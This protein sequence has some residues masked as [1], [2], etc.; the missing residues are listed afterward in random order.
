MHT[1]KKAK[2]NQKT[3]LKVIIC[4]GLF[5]L[6]LTA[7]IFIYSSDYSRADRTAKAALQSTGAVQVTV[8]ENEVLFYPESGSDTGLIFYP[9]G[10]VEYTAYAPLLH[11]LAEEGIT[12]IIV[13]MPLQL[14]FLDI[15]AANRV[16]NEHPEINHWYLAGHSLGG[17]AASSYAQKNADKLDGLIL[18]ASYSTKPLS[19]FE[20]L[21]VY[22]S[23][24]GVLNRS[25]Y[26]ESRA[27][28]PENSKELV[29]SGGNHAQFGN[30]GIQDGDGVA[31]ISTE[32][33][34]EIT[35]NEILE[36]IRRRF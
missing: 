35:R 33:Q 15:N 30:Y 10:K 8:S 11:S 25:A 23:E 1:I 19:G 24:D 14:A 6:L 9:G 4:I 2:K 5:V 36:F 22:G 20:V 13:K 31:T 34:Q 32:I 29:I 3:L 27:N 26:E 17:V 16:M 21:S 18:L 7:A 12:C 28:L